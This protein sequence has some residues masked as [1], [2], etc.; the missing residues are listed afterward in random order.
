[1][2]TPTIIQNIDKENLSKPFTFY[3]YSE[4]GEWMG[5]PGY[6]PWRPCF[7]VICD[8]QEHFDF[9]YYAVCKLF[10]YGRLKCVNPHLPIPALDLHQTIDIIDLFA[11]LFFNDWRRCQAAFAA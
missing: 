8:N 2:H 11:P 3:I 5:H 10:L 9:Y 7:A 6:Y 4:E 1:M